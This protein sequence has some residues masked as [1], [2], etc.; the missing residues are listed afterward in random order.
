MHITQF[1]P[2]LAVELPDTHALL[3]KAHLVVH[4]AVASVILHGSHGR[5][6]GA[7]PDSDIDLAFLVELVD[8]TGDRDG[9]FL[10]ILRT[11][12]TKWRSSTEVDLAVMFDKCNCGLR[13]MKADGKSPAFCDHTKGCMG[14]Y[15]I[16]KGF[17]GYVPDTITDCSKIRPYM[18]VWRR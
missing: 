4:P 18:V 14:L 9:L 5:L 13:C 16:Q 8:L 12:F 11:T 1:G 6:G 3:R 15:K 7:R 10:D 2:E 17:N